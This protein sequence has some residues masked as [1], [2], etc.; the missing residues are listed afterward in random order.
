MYMGRMRIREPQGFLVEGIILGFLQCFL[1]T[2]LLALMP[3]QTARRTTML[4]GNERGCEV[5]EYFTGAEITDLPM[6]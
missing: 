5:D 4:Q 1:Q 6:L 2:E 3:W